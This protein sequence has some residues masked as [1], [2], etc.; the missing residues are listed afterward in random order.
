MGEHNIKRNTNSKQTLEEN[1][2]IQTVHSVDT[3]NFIMG[4]HNIRTNTNSKQ[5]LKEN[6]LIQESKQKTN[7][8]EER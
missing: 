8:D 6:T 7:K 2:L 5:T 1:T 3:G 4:E